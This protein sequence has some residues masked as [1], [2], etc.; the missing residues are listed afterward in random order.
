M[1]AVIE[2]GTVYAE[3]IHPRHILLRWLG[4]DNIRVCHEVQVGE[5][6][7]KVGSIN[8]GLAGRLGEEKAMTAGTKDVDSVVPGQV[9]Q[10][11]RE[12][13]LT[14]AEHMGTPPKG[15]PPVLLVH[16]VH[17]T[18]CDYV[19]GMDETIKHL[20]CTLHDLL[21]LLCEGVLHWHLHIQYHVKRI[22][23]VR[24]QGVEAREIEV[25]LNVVL[26]HLTEELVAT[27]GAE[28]R[29][30]GAVLVRS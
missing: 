20:G 13:R 25:I 30:P 2:A 24:H 12:D 6:G 21:L 16:C 27:E 17:A 15:C 10:S 23:I 4:R 11:H 19:S 3:S 7:S 22:V 29:D 14:L 28:P 1:V 8:I 9:T 18:V 5:C 26:V